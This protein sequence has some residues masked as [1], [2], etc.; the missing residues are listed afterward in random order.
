MVKLINT[1]IK[2]TNFIFKNK[3]NKI[4]NAFCGPAII[5]QTFQLEK[6]KT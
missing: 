4:K 5:K 3:H 6:P 1:V 2:F